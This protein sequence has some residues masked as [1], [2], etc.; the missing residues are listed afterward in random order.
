[1][2]GFV[3]ASTALPAVAEDQ[4]AET[5][6]VK[7]DEG[8]T[9]T[10]SDGRFKLKTTGK[11]QF[12]EDTTNPDAGSATSHFFI[13]RGRIELEG[14]VFSENTG[15][16]LNYAVADKGASLIKDF[17]VNQ[18]IATRWVQVRFGQ[19]KTPLS[20]QSINGDF[21]LEMPEASELV[22]FEQANRDMGV[23]IHNGFDSSP[24]G[25]E[26]AIGIFNGALNAEP[27]TPVTTTCTPGMMMT[28]SCTS[29]SMLPTNVPADWEPSF[30]GR[31]GWNYGGIK[32]Y[33]EADLEGGPLRFA[34]GVSYRENI[35]DLTGLNHEVHADAIVKLYGL[36]VSGAYVWYENADDDG[37][38]GYYVQ[39]GYFI[40]PA[41][42]Q[43]VAR[44]ASIDSSSSDGQTLEMRA[45][46]NYYFHDHR[47]KVMTDF[48]VVKDTGTADPGQ[49][50][51]DQFETRLM[52][53][54]VF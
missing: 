26:Y 19:F 22:N 2:L 3:L 33:Q 34:I 15:Y 25:F 13:A 44:F 30:V 6:T 43:V 18:K 41:H 42:L 47:Y 10:S 46:L 12:R 16:T 5:A 7:Y 52:A 21:A 36:D 37:Q 45:G 4:T 31:V 54:L 29:T 17:Y 40:T 1:M 38:Q 20:R 28:I 51:T 32:A 24:N 39:S 35:E 49:T 27:N 53:Q 11:L 8:T 23:M 9:I 14:F 48:G 50:K